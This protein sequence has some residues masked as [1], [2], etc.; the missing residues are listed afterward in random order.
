MGTILRIGL[1]RSKSGKILGRDTK[2]FNLNTKEEWGR[3][4]T[5]WSYKRNSGKPIFISKEKVYNSTVNDILERHCKKAKIPV[6]SVHGLRHTHA[7]LLLFAG[8]SIGSVARRLG[9]ASM[10]TTQKTYLHIIH[11]LEN[12]DVDLVMRSLSSLS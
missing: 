12:Q 6:I 1:G 7:S 10:T 3:A 11:E 4:V 2:W 5:E 8:V 9:H